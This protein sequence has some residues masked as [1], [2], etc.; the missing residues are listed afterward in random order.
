MDVKEAVQ[1]RRALRSFEKTKIDPVV[2]D[3]LIE[4]ASLSAS[5]FNNQPWRYVFVNDDAVLK[6]LHE[7]LPK[8]NVWATV[9]PLIIVVCSKKESDC[10][11]K[12]REYFLFDCGL[13]VS[14]LILEATELGLVA[15]P[16]AG[17]DED[18][19][20]EILGIPQDMTAITFII[21]GVHSP[22]ISPLLSEKQIKDETTRPPRLAKEQTVF[23]NRFPS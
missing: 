10:V 2:I 21:V 9:A 22:T 13:S 7:A 1:K 23:F 16:I 20:K 3:S 11:I 6:K 8:G 19:A 18:K 14:Q 12:N 17:F 4:A 15:H 5:C